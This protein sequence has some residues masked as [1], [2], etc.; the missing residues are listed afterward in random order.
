VSVFPSTHAQTR[1]VR[2]AAL[3]ETERNYFDL[4]HTQLWRQLLRVTSFSAAV[5]FL[6]FDH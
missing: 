6:L 1:S 3:C 5:D 2:T 4:K